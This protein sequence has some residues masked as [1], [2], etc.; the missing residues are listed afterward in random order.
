MSIGGSRSAVLV[1]RTRKYMFRSIG[2]SVIAILYFSPSRFHSFS[3][4]RAI[5]FV[6]WVLVV[7]SIGRRWA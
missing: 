5:T 2:G 1:P 6:V 7:V 4:N 3:V